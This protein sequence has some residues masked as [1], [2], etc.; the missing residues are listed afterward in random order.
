MTTKD[1]A[2]AIRKQLKSHG[3]TARHVSVR[4]RHYTTDA[5]IYVTIKDASVHG[6]TVEKIARS[7]E[8]IDRCPNS[9]EILAGGNTYV[10]VD[11]DRDLLKATAKEIEPSLSL[12]V[13]QVVEILGLKVW[14]A[15]QHEYRVSVANNL[16]H[17][18]P[19]YTIGGAAK[20][21]AQALLDGGITC[22]GRF[23]AI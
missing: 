9:L 1:K 2:Q 6:H 17:F 16:N 11:Y 14:K 10:R 22:C 13:G 23:E 12:V 15:T 8:Q 21:A 4:C 20:M 3:W 5:A 7:F 19:A 18:R